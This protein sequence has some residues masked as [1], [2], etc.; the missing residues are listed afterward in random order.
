V[1]TITIPSVNWNG[2]ETITFTA[3]DDD[4]TSP[5][6]ASN[7]ATFTVTPVND[8]PVAKNKS[9]TTKEDTA[10][11][12]TLM[13]SDV[14]G[15]ALSYSVVSWPTNGTLSGAAPNLSYQPDVSYSGPDS[16][17]FRANDGQVD[18]N[19][20]T[21]SI[22]VTPLDTDK[23]GMPDFWEQ[24]NALDPYTN[25]AAGDPDGDGFTNLSEYRMGTDPNDPNSH[26]TRSMPWIPLLLLGN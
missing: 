9:V 4:A 2:S 7:A 8:A 20:A 3:T 5:L 1:A 16:F 23:D 14:D 21:V 6:S 11:A 22:K 19:I 15:D 13:A 26:P 25:D 10:V 18:S 17:T 24:A 12:I